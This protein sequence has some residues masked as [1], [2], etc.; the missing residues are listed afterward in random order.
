MSRRMYS[1][2]L[3]SKFFVI[4][5]RVHLKTASKTRG[6]SCVIAACTLLIRH[7]KSESTSGSRASGVE[8]T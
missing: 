2:G 7:V 1:T 6:T 5:S 3:S 8:R 4:I